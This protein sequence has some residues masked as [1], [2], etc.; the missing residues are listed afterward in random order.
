M[1]Q[2]RGLAARKNRGY[3][4]LIGCGAAARVAWIAAAALY[5]LCY[6]VCVDPDVGELS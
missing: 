1:R 5:S 2:T 6:I 3:G 4:F